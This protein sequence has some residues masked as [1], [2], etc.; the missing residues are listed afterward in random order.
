MRGV[1]LSNE[2][3]QF[4][5]NTEHDLVEILDKGFHTYN[6]WGLAVEKYVVTPPSDYLQFVPIWVQIRNIPVNHYTVQAITALGE[7]VGQVLEVVFD[8]TRA[9]NQGF[10][11]VKVKFDISKPLRRS[12]II[13]L[14]HGQSTTI[15]FFYERVQKRC[16]CCQRL[17]HIQ[18]VCPILVRKRQDLDDERRSGKFQE[19]NKPPLILKE[20]DPLFGVL[21]EDQV[22]V[23][24]INGRVRIAPEVL[25]GLRQYLLLGSG[26]E[27]KLREDKVMR[28]LGEAVRDPITQKTVLRLEP[29]PL[30]SDDLSRGKGIVFGYDTES[31][32]CPSS[33]GCPSD[34]NVLEVACKAYQNPIV[35]SSL[36]ILQIRSVSQESSAQSSDFHVDSTGYRIGFSEASP[37]GVYV[38]K[39]KPRRRQSKNKRKL[40]GKSVT[41]MSDFVLKTGVTSGQVAKRKAFEELEGVSK[42]AKSNSPVMVPNEG[43]SNP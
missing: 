13:R 30:V 20:S 43:L 26:E 3:F 22:G 6:E 8:E 32:S 39:A 33:M 29:D 18:E 28:T 25:K 11:R 14:P 38:K 40:K 37:S 42:V 7:L 34:Q 23:N 27:R 24:P 12:K 16:Y 35:P 9:Q 21:R 31:S 41:P 5:F 2:K 19:K 15:F 36:A 1:A 10:V 4:I 17:T